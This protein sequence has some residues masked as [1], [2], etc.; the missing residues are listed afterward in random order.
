MRT[1]HWFAV[2]MG[3]CLALA[4]V[5]TAT[6]QPPGMPTNGNPDQVGMGMMPSPFAGAYGQV[7]QTYSGIQPAGYPPNA[8]AWP[9]VS[10][11]A[12][13]PVDSTAY[14]DGFWFNRIL[15][16]NRRYYFSAEALLA[17][18]RGGDS[19]LIGAPGVNPVSIDALQGQNGTGTTTTGNLIFGT[20]Q[21]NQA[22]FT[23]GPSRNVNANG[24]GGNGGGGNGTGGAAVVNIFAAQDTGNLANVMTSGGFRGTWG[25]FNPDDTGFVVSGF[26]QGRATSSWNLVDPLLDINEFSGNYNPL[27][28]LH[29]WFG[30]PLGSSGTNSTITNSTGTI[31]TGTGPDGD[32]DGD[33]KYGAVQPYDMGVYLRFNSQLMGANSDYYF[34][35]IY[36][37][38]AVKLRPL[39]GARYLHLRESFSFDGSDSG[40]GYTVNDPSS[41]G[42]GG[43]GGNNGGGGGGTTTGTGYLT[44]SALD[45]IF[46]NPNV[47]HSNLVSSTL[48]Q[49]AG[50]EIG[51]R[52]DLGPQ[53]AKFQMWGNT[54]FG[55]LANVTSRQ[56]TGYGIGNAFN[57]ISPNTVPQMPND[58]TL[59]AF[60]TSQTTTN[61]SPMF[62]QSINV[63][64]PV[65]NLVPYLNRLEVFEKAQLQAGYTFLY[66]G[67]VYR[68]HNT[69]IWNQFPKTPQLNG[70]KSDFFNSNFNLGVEW[71]Y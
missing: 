60:S 1:R 53:N 6:A 9:N 71:E 15:Q 49:M 31:S 4:G 62:E 27:L 37:R 51:L 21:F 44:P 39:L 8:N 67:Q 12:G 52:F 23:T 54:K 22:V 66:V 14:E 2:M 56:I 70:Q 40:L 26:V 50:P 58:P 7:P 25:W 63:K 13:P 43:G 11:F 46:S 68:P 29:A 20:T 30:L 47:L 48:S 28:H 59:T 38:R 64:F 10:P 61:F 16:K 42:T 41:G 36:E 19:T 32:T 34:N 18:T 65:F 17:H 5:G 69:I 35:S 55:A 33:G 57:I 45:A 24:G 3:G